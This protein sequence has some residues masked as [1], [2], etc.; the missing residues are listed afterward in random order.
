MAMKIVHDTAAIAANC[1]TS[2]LQQQIP[3]PCCCNCRH[4]LRGIH[5]MESNLGAWSHPLP[6]GLGSIRSEVDA[7]AAIIAAQN[8]APYGTPFDTVGS[9]G[10]S[11]GFTGEQTDGNHQVFLR[12]RY[13]NP[14]IGVFNSLDPFEGVIQRPMSLNGYSWVEANVPNAVDPSGMSCG[15]CD[16]FLSDPVSYFICTE[17]EAS[18]TN[19][20][21]NRR[22]A[23]QAAWNLARK[24]A[25]GL[26]Y[27]VMR[28]PSANFMSLALYA[29]GIP[30]TVPSGTQQWD[31]NRESGWRA[32]INGSN[33]T[34]LQVW[35]N[36]NLP[37]P[38]NPA[39]DKRLIGYLHGATDP[40]AGVNMVTSPASLAIGPIDARP[41]AGFDPRNNDFIE[42]FGEISTLI[43][44]STLVDVR[45]GD[46]LFID[47]GFPDTHGYMVVGFG[48][49]LPC[50][51]VRESQSSMS[52]NGNDVQIPINVS[53]IPERVPYVA[54]WSG[55]S[56][57]DIVPFYCSR[58]DFSH[59]TWTFIT[60][61]DKWSVRRDSI[62]LSNFNVTTTGAIVLT[63][64]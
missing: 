5:A 27:S 9:F 26:G 19:F 41:I 7:N 55:S 54:D 16:Q 6:D 4:S 51:I 30:M 44:T 1:V 42:N 59:N 36:H 28:P 34:G 38:L 35:N 53:I 14:S 48:P 49:A 8:Y 61:P 22:N 12:A 11:F 58:S 47:T 40:R 31:Q 15:D 43:N 39:T 33:L 57:R 50:F 45:Q 29:G 56:P 32:R 17:I 60:V 46:Y 25:S 2:I 52:L 23:A 62:F 37:S 24:G 20:E 21:Y 63:G 10:S 3:S 64:N 18:R 13:Y